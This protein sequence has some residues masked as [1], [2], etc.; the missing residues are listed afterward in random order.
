M[1]DA[2]DP[3]VSPWHIDASEFYELESYHEQMGFL[4]RYAVLAPSGHNTQPWSFRITQDGIEVYADYTRRLMA[5][6]PKDRELI[7]S[8][9][10]AITNFRVAAAHFGFDTTVL[11][12]SR[13]EEGAW[14]ALI[15]ARET[16]GP[17]RFLAS[18]FGAITRRHTNRAEFDGQPL[19]PEAVERL[20]DVV[21]RFPHTFRLIP[22][23]DRRRVAE[24]IEEG[25]R[26][27]M[28]RPSVRAELA[29]AAPWALRRFDV[30]PWQGLRDR[31][32]AESASALL[33][34]TADDDRTSLLRAGE[35]LELLLLTI[36]D[37][38][39]Q[40]SF[41]NQP[42]GVPALRDLLASLAGA[43]HPP[44]L[45]LRIGSGPEVD[46]AMPRRRLETVLAGTRD[47]RHVNS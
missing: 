33:V 20:C 37:A 46:Q 17:D 14:V 27:L 21:E 32:L 4:L 3:R 10:A 5:V 42:I 15:W 41:L 22:A 9:G 35:A 25:E 26:E 23:H 16:C 13:P 36:A 47:E 31:R 11:Y 39:L 12:S 6:D 38:R 44:Q 2:Y 43:T 45:L 8:V 34:I 30:G 40:Y 18:L 24:L 19:D 28:S 1:S 7:M 29:S